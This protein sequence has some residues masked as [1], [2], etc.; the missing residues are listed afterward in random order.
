[1]EGHVPKIFWRC[2]PTFALDLCPPLSNSFRRHWQR[3]CIGDRAV[4]YPKPQSTAL[5]P[6]TLTCSNRAMR[7]PGLPF[8]G[9]HPCIQRNCIRLFML[10]FFEFCTQIATCTY[11]FRLFCRSQKDGRLSWPSR[12]THCRQFA[13]EVVTYQP[14]IRHRSEKSASQ[15][16]TS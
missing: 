5:Y 12:L 4:V 6:R 11:I 3:C 9:R 15:R 13:H 1:M 7:S 14:P 2:A 16:S 8:N 10:I